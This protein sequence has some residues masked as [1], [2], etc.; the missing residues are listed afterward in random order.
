MG[1][2][3]EPKHGRELYYQNRSKLMAVAIQTTPKFAAAAPRVL[4]EAPY[5]EGSYDVAPDGRFIMIDHKQSEPP[6]SQITL[7]TNWFEELKRRVP[8]P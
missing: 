3:W 1:P 2:S 7:I 5:V 4:F 8:T 6:A